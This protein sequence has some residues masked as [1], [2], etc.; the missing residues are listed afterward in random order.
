MARSLRLSR[1]DQFAFAHLYIWNNICRP[2]A[3]RYS[4]VEVSDTTEAQ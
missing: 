2:Y 4:D 3:E 1:E